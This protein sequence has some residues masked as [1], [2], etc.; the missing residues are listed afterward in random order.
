MLRNMKSLIPVCLL[1]VVLAAGCGSDEA[2][3]TAEDPT[4]AATSASAADTSTPASAEASTDAVEPA[5]GKTHQLDGLTLTTPKGWSDVGEKQTSDTVLSVMHTGMDDTPERLY[6][7]RVT[8]NAPPEAVAKSSRTALQEV[9]ATKVAEQDVVEVAGQ[10][11]VYSTA[12]RKGGGIDERFS[13]YVLTGDQATWV[14]TF[15]I[16]RW[17]QRPVPQDVIDSVLMTVEVD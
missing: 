9:G 13:Q 4:D 7:R 10:E 1:T 5:S 16:N 17:Q 8:T 3:S 11:A 14:L 6:V 15:S 12:R 2:A